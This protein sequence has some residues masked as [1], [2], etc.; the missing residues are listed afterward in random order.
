M[1]GCGCGDRDGVSSPELGVA[2]V[3]C[4]ARQAKILVEEAEENNLCVETVNGKW[5]RWYKCGLCE[6]QY[7]GVV[8]CALG[9]ACW[10][11]YLGRPE[12][13]W[14]RR[15]AMEMLG[16]GLSS[17][18][19]YEDA[20]PMQEA[21]LSL[22]R[23]HGA[24]ESSILAMKRNISNTYT[25]SGRLELALN[26]DQDIY[27]GRVKLDG[28]E[29]GNTLIA[30]S[31]YAST[32]QCATRFEE[33]KE[34]LRKII[35]VARRVLGK[36]DLTTLTASLNNATT[37]YEDPNATLDDLREAAETLEDAARIARRV[38]GGAHPTANRLS[39]NL[40]ASRAVLR[41]HET[42]PGSA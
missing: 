20:L 27:Y 34:L 32:L 29:H 3:S 30:A 39:V 19:H 16:S 38:L 5:A 25:S 23:R 4:L 36:G 35:A 31:N 24:S 18:K 1:R 8:L 6:Q 12:E 14:T 2:H 9:W 10:K 11:T 41:A 28:E 7:H 40:R 26:M 13:H 17:V 33:V 21:Q 22:A 42:P 15:Y 37:L